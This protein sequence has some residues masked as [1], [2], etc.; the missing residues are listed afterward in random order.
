MQPTN[1]APRDRLIVALDLPD[2]AAAEAMIARLGDSV[3][4][5]KIGYQ[6]GLC[7]RVAAGPPACRHRQEGVR[8]SQA[9]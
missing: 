9:A 1:I 3:T 8:R 2:V 6:L 7:R 4:F 5:Y